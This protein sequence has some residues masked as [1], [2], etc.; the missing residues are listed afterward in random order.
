M[1][2]T[3]EI[4]LKSSSAEFLDSVR[5]VTANNGVRFEGD[6]VSGRFSGHGIEGHYR[7][8][9]DVLALNITK[10]PMVVPWTLIEN[11]VRS[12]FA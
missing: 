4:K 9:D 3:F 1:S 5:A 10:K 8:V 2:K 6:Q 11:K 12:F 7:I